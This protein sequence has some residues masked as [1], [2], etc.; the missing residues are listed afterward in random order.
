MDLQTIKRTIE[1]GSLRTTEEFQR[2]IMLMCMNA[3][4][5]NTAGHNVHAMA[6]QLMTDALAK[7][8]VI[9]LLL[10]IC[11]PFQARS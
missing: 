1:S 11:D 5:Y 4:V 8:E 10:F 7:I 6:R 2:D 3:I 9:Y